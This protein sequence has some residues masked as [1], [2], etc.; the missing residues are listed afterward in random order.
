[1]RESQQ[2]S[3][4]FSM[5]AAIPLM[6]NSLIF[7]SPNSALVRALS[8]FPLTAPTTMMLRLPLTDVSPLDLALSL[9]L[10][11][12]TIPLVVW[13]GAKVFR[14]GLLLYGKRPGAKQI[15]QALRQA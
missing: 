1:M 12:V 11:A 14:M 6:F 8:I 15:W 2:L 3:A 13:G 4:V 5:A 10:L 9:G 7:A